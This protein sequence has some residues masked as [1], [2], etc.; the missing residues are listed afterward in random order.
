MSG[1]DAATS[2]MEWHDIESNAPFPMR[3]VFN[4]LALD[5]IIYLVLALFFDNVIPGAFCL[6]VSLS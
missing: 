5:F 4:W 3:R 1:A 6:A 2:G